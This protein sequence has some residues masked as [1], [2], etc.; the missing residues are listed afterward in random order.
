MSFVNNSYL[1]SETQEPLHKRKNSILTNTFNIPGIESI[2]EIIKDEIVEPDDLWVK[3]MQH[4]VLKDFYS[5]KSIEVLYVSSGKIEVEING[6]KMPFSEGSFCLMNKNTE[7]SYKQIDQED[8]VFHIFIEEK[9]FDPRFFNLVIDNNVFS[10]YIYKSLYVKKDLKDYLYINQISNSVAEIINSLIKETKKNNNILYSYIAILFIR[11][12]EHQTANYMNE[13]KSVTSRKKEFILQIF[14]HIKKNIKNATLTSIA[15]E[16]HLHPNYLCKVIRDVSG[17]TFTEILN[18]IKAEVAA[19]MLEMTEDSIENIATEIGYNNTNYFYKIFKDIYGITPGNYREKFL[20]QKSEFSAADKTIDNK[21]IQINNII[22]KSDNVYGVAIIRQLTKSG[23]LFQ[24]LAYRKD[25]KPKIVFMPAATEFN[26]IMSVGAG[27]KIVAEQYNA[28]FYTFAPKHEDINVQMKLLH[29]SINQKVDAIIINTHDEYAAAP[30]LK[31]AVDNGIMVCIINNDNIDCPALVH[32]IIGYRQ[33][34]ATYQIGNY[35]VEKMK[36]NIAKVGIIQGITG[37][38]SIERCSGFIDAIKPHKNFEI[39]SILNGRWNVKG[40]YEAAMNILE[41]RPDVNVIFCANDHEAI[42]AVKAIKEINR[43]GIMVLSND[44]DI[45]GLKN[46]AKGDITATM[47]TMPHEMGKIAAQVVIEGLKGKFLG[48]Y[49]ETPAK[50]TDNSNVEVFL[51]LAEK[52]SII[53]ANK[54]V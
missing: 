17:K 33:R 36:G 26:Y 45:S 7:R 3:V 2:G 48:G 37:Y 32:A 28:E 24:N 51:K 6:Q 15:E 42:G 27:I 41:S 43:K 31:K 44:G 22:E 46:I 50:I 13:E 12:F 38:H 18:Q 39:V 25:D 4:P 47:S 23:N 8:N 54:K 53:L 10:N 5:H 1:V 29:E 21:I 52:R 19:L 9:L 30:L 40:G 34:K 16:L 49:V 14:E 20:K 11:L 35:A